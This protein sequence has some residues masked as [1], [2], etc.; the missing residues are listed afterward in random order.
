[1][2][3]DLYEMKRNQSIEKTTLG[4]TNPT[5]IGPLTFSVYA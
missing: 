5:L 2:A 4:M 3:E 1:M